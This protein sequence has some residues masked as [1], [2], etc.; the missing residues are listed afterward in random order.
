MTP[1]FIF[2]VA[3]LMTVIFSRSI[4]WAQVPPNSPYTINEREN[5]IARELT[6]L[7]AT[8]K[9]QVDNL[10]EFVNEAERHRCRSFFDTLTLTC[11]QSEV[12]KNCESG[13]GQHLASCAALS[14]VFL[15]NKVNERQFLSR[16]ERFRIAQRAE[17]Y[18]KAYTKML[19]NKYAVLGVEMMR[20]SQENCSRNDHTCE[21]RQIDE[22]CSHHA[23]SQNIAWQACVSAL[24]WFVSE[25]G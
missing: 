20:T 4:A 10:R 24:E 25:G 22:Y 23:D 1:H 8:N 12:K 5:L 6:A 18:D 3:L 19:E 9:T 17:N 2:A 21:A 14:D 16:Q 7:Q 15:V 13:L 11:L